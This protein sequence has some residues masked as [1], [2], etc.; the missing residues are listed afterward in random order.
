MPKD[1]ARRIARE[2]LEKADS[3]RF[4][5]DV[6]TMSSADTFPQLIKEAFEELGCS[7]KS[8]PDNP[9]QLEVH[10]NRGTGDR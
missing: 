5:V 4:T 9:G 1:Y 6:P 10:I 7:V 3:D 2:L 8:D